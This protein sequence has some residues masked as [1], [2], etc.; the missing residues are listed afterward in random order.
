[1]N[2]IFKKISTIL[3]FV[4]LLFIATW[5]VFQDQSKNTGGKKDRWSSDGLGFRVLLPETLVFFDTSSR[6]MDDGEIQTVSFII[7]GSADPADP[8]VPPSLMVS[9]LPSMG[10]TASFWADRKIFGGYPEGT[11]VSDRIASSIAREDCVQQ[12]EGINAGMPTEQT[13]MHVHYC[14]HDD[15]LYMLGILANTESMFSTFENLEK[16]FVRDFEFL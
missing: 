4:I 2:H 16:D 13:L 15:Q 10:R 8:Y 3:F 9:V 5:F 14:V 7:E 1:M 11:V 12:K 6:Q